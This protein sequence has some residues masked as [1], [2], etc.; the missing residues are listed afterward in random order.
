LLVGNFGDGKINAFN[1]ATNFNDG[2]LKDV[3]NA[4]IAIDG[5][6]G[7]SV[8]NGGQGGSTGKVYFSAGPGD[9]AHGLFGVLSVP[10]PAS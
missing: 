1:L 9:E 2:P 5:L 8:G 7:L 6:W 4:P 10:E 3:N